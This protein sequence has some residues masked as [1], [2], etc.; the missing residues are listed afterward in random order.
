MI[1]SLNYVILIDALRALKEG[2]IRYCE[3]LGFT[4]DEMNALN[5]MTLDDFFIISRA[6]AQFMNVIIH[7]E[8]L[9]LL[10]LQS[11]Q[12][13]KLQHQINRAISLGGSLEL[14]N[15]YFGLTSH[16]TCARRRLLGLRVA[17]GRTRLPNEDID[18]DI[19]LR[20]QKQRVDNIE[21]LHAL[22]A[23]MQ[24][25]EELAGK[26]DAPT[27]TAV[28]QRIV[29]SEKEKLVRGKANAR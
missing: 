28:W 9:H 29:L 4:Y 27:L 6:S 20:W 12:E 15:R 7:H 24:I 26:D 23:M 16:E 11:D 1:P 19:W 8:A 10:L 18:A 3:K 25:T 2:K 17:Q 13:V 14:I 5:R 21:S 22:D